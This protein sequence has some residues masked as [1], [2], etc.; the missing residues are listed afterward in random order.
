MKEELRNTF[1]PFYNGRTETDVKAPFVELGKDN[2]VELL[3][4][5]HRIVQTYKNSE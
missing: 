1:V 4:F 5:S 3:H 2:G